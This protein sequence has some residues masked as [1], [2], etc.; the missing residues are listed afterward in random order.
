MFVFRDSAPLSSSAVVV[1]GRVIPRDPPK[2]NRDARSLSG[3]VFEA[4][5]EDSLKR[6]RRRRPRGG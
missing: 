2:W 3:V 6:R 4:I 1:V 5:F